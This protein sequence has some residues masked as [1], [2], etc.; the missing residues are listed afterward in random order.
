MMQD[1][2]H[3]HASVAGFM[4]KTARSLATFLMEILPEISDD[5]WKQTVVNNLSYQQQRRLEQNNIT[6]LTSLDLAALLRLLDRN[7]YQISTNLSLT[8]EDRHFVKEMLTIRNRWA[9]ADTE[10]FSV[11][12]AYRDLDTLQRFSSLIKTDANFLQEIRI[13][14]TNLL[15]KSEPLPL[16]INVDTDEATPGTNK[17][18]VEFEPGQIVFLKSNSAVKGAVVAILPGEP[19]NRFKVFV[20]G[21]TQTYYASQLQCENQQEDNF[22]FL[23]CDKFNSYLTALQIRYP[24]LTTLYSLN[25][26]R[27]DF[28]PYQFRPVLKFIRSDRP[29]LLIADGVG[30]GK[31]IEA[32]LILRELQARRDIR[33]VLIICPRPLVVEQKWRQEMKRFDESFTHLNGSTLRYC[34]NEM[35]L[36]GVWPQQYQKII[37]PYTL[38]DENLL[39]GTGKGGKGKRKKGLLN[40]DPFPRFDLVIVDETHHIRNENTFNHKAVRFFCDHAEAVVFLTAT[41]IQLGNQDLFVQLNTLRP[42]LVIDQKSFEHM[43]E[44]N[45]FIN[46]AVTL[47]R[48]QESDW[49]NK[50]VEALDHAAA[51]SWGQVILKLNPEFQRVKNLLTKD[52]IDPTERVQLITDME[53]LHTFSGIISRTRRRDIGDFTV[54]KPETVI[55]EFT[56]DHKQFHDELLRI[57]AEIF[58]RLHGDRNVKF[59]MTTIRRQAASCLFGLVPFIADILNRHLDELSWDEAD[60]SAQIPAIDAVASIET[61]IKTISDQAQQLDP[62]DPKLD[63]LR[64][65]INDKQVLPNNKLML[66]S[67]FRHT[68]RYLYDHLLDDGFRVGIVH[69]GTPDEDR[70]L[71]RKR[72]ER[73]RE[74]E[75]ALDILLFSEIGCEGL[76]YQFCDCIVNYDLPWNPMRIEQRIGRIDRN[77]QKSE[78]VV[79]YNMI[80]PGTVDADIYMSC[81]FRIGVFN[82]A[83]G[84]SE[85]IL[86]EITHEIKNIAENFTITDEE[87]KK[88]LEQLADN[89]IRLVRENE[90]LEQKQL[91]LFGIRL[92][93]EQMN[94]EI[95]NASSHWLSPAAIQKLVSNYLQNVCGK[96][97]EFILGDK[98]LKTLRLA[99]ETR[100]HL[101]GDFQKLPRQNTTT[102]REW[103]T[104]LKGGNPH[105]LVTFES[106]CAM[107]HPEAA[108]VMPLH[109][110]VKQASLKFAGGSQIV[111]SLKVSSREVPEGKYE[112][113]IYQWQF[114]G[115][116]EDLLLRPIASSQIVTEHLSTLLKTAVGAGKEVIADMDKSVWDGLDSQHYALW[117][118]ARTEHQERTRER[119]GY[120]RESL[121]TSHKARMALLEE[122]LR[123]ATNEK[124]QKMRQGQI[125]AAQADYARRVQELD[126]AMERAD[127][128]SEPVAYGVLIVEGYEH[129]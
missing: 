124:I 8:S 33:S 72:F 68:L 99:Q 3:I 28:I 92:P 54:R 91:E 79:I 75:D 71:L 6:A 88:K 17:N 27:I 30:V 98:E 61:Q 78:S 86:G 69:G 104:W 20:D 58:S 47:V 126:I 42:D 53:A 65:I 31:T 39:Q 35:D 66:F 5:W 40:L 63:A 97:H 36:E 109:P 48:T 118:K 90:D 125:T 11:E 76:D 4:S 19:E 50:A 103:E 43:A 127:V 16:P 2:V 60:N 32:G 84:S 23:S 94:K 89:K 24:G 105:L 80:T 123:Q 1:K 21:T 129:D 10:G 122:Q 107:D 85:E 81:L 106:K 82:S 57:Q 56:P 117:S 115:I 96:E 37:V 93:Q 116:K 15:V 38:F 44:P 101:L 110:L 100:N 13:A 120:R 7:W 108:F 73:A 111:T 12:D 87:R 52:G 95:E 29:R 113:A 26:A 18:I 34:I 77:G 83:L 51:T 67:S 46:K 25:A 74:N 128:T 59:M 119:A 121:S 102:Y 70:I 112:F 41:P 64:K 22:E 9:H 114:H 55:V 45:P 14:K 62:Y 49:G